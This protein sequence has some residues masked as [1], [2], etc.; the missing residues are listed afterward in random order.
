MGDWL[1]PKTETPNVK[2]QE[3][4]KARERESAMRFTAQQE[5]GLGLALLRFPRDGSG[6]NP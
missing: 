6:L 5:Q 4:K 2:Q 1:K 3:E